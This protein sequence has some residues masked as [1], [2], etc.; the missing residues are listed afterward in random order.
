MMRACASA[1]E[2]TVT[3]SLK[4]VLN[5]AIDNLNYSGAAKSLFCTLIVS[6]EWEIFIHYKMFILISI[7]LIDI[8]TIIAPRNNLTN[9]SLAYSI[10]S[11]LSLSQFRA[12]L[13]C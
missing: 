11:S 3:C 12:L 7:T 5:G 8:I 2:S 10:L 13:Q 9:K 4:N 6:E 1:S